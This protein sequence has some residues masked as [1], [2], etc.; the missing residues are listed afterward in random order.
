MALHRLSK[1]IATRLILCGIA[2]VFVGSLV[3][4]AVLSHIMQE[5]IHSLVVSQQRSITDYMARDVEQRLSRRQ[6]ALKDVASAIP[7]D[8]LSQ[9]A[10][11]QRWLAARPPHAWFPGDLQYLDAAA[12][13]RAEDPFLSGVLS[14]KPL[15]ASAR[16]GDHATVSLSFAVPVVQTDGVVAGLLI[17][18][19][20]PSTPG[21]LDLIPGSRVGRAGGVQLVSPVDGAIIVSSETVRQLPPVSSAVLATLNAA[22]DKQSKVP[23][24]ADVLRDEVVAGSAIPGT[25]WLLIARQPG[26]E[27]FAPLL[28]IQQFILRYSGVAAMA[29]LLPFALFVFLIFRP[30][31]HAAR[32]AERMTSGEI[33]LEP[34][35]VRRDD[36]IGHLTKA[37]NRLLLK[38]TESQAELD[39]MAHHDQ[40]TGLPNRVLLADRLQQALERAHRSGSRLAILCLDLDG[41]KQINDTL[42]HDA[43]DNALRQVAERLAETVRL[44]D[45]L[46]RVGGDEFVILLPDLGPEDRGQ[47][48]Q[49]IV[50]RCLKA[51]EAPFSI[52]GNH[53]QLGVSIGVA[54]G[55]EGSRA[56][57]LLS[58]ADRAM[59]RAKSAGGRRAETIDNLA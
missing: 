28:R 49:A 43:G 21:L 9:P 39:R 22:P 13:G 17:G 58:A 53:Y 48:A 12:V 27:A 52:R 56:D 18:H 54:E 30:L 14:G 6:A 11:L 8:L 38:V 41:F 33:P 46:A 51:M 7:R 40:L 15:M 34:L 10:A 59:Y 32:H 25:P 20:P 16:Y 3:R 50:D 1:S 36:E 55:G 45:T 19:V 44:T 2:I 24:A 29:V 5:D 47:T 4:Y 37:F 31:I 42:G 23:D 57:V 35:P 26:D